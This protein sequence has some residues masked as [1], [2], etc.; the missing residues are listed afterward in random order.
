MIP[1]SSKDGETVCPKRVW[2]L[3]TLADDEQTSIDGELPQGL[4]FHLKQCAPCRE[5]ADGVLA[6]ASGLNALGGI[7]PDDS[8]DARA[9]ERLSNALRAGAPLTGRV[10]VPDDP[11]FDAALEAYRPPWVGYA[12]FSAAAAIIFLIGLV[13]VFRFAT[14]E[15][16]P[17]G[18]TSG[19]DPRWNL[20]PGRDAASAQESPEA[21]ANHDSQRR[22]PAAQTEVCLHAT[23]V[24]AAECDRP[25]VAHPAM[26]T[27]AARRGRGRTTTAPIPLLQEEIDKSR[28]VGSIVPS[29]DRP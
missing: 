12:R 27:P 16:V 5:V 7:E 8:L 21:V 17:S 3:S 18:L 11:I 13:G 15:T 26:P 24:E 23:Y 10:N 6:V 1:T 20:A 4:R 19:T 25:N 22:R 29:D 9:N 2:V 14:V 28:E